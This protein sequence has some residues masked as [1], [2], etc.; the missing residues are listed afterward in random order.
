MS[1]YAETPVE[2]LNKTGLNDKHIALSEW[3]EY[4]DVLPFLLPMDGRI[5]DAEPVIKQI[6]TK[7]EKQPETSET[8]RIKKS[9][10][11]GD[12]HFY[13]QFLPLFGVTL[14]DTVSKGRRLRNPNYLHYETRVRQD[15]ITDIE[16]RK[17]FF[18]RYRINPQLE[19]PWYAMHWGISK[20]ATRE[21]IN[22]YFEGIE[23][24][25][26]KARKVMART[27]YTRIQWLDKS[28]AAV[29]R[30]FPFHSATIRRWIRNNVHDCEWKPPEN[31]SNYRWYTGNQ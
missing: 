11:T 12:G 15:P 22:R 7:I 13:P 30:T 20:S 28:N 26:A 27:I 1:T 21:I 23:A 18:E 10:I 8:F 5:T 24:E 3:A 19:N 2:K 29:Y 16:K 4:H 6:K 14:F 17:Q 9:Y 25:R 31:P